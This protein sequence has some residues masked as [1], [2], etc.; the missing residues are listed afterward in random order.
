MKRP[1]TMAAFAESRTV[2]GRVGSSP[3]LDV[4]MYPFGGVTTATSGP[5]DAD[6]GAAGW[7]NPCNRTV[8]VSIRK[9][10]KKS[11]DE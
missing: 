10:E 8:K 9:S 11:L 2:V 1:E 3:C 6:E 7:R 4:L 5:V